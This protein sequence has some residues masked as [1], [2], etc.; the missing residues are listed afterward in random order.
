MRYTKAVTRACVWGLIVLKGK[1]IFFIL[2]S[3]YHFNYLMVRFLFFATACVE[4][5]GPSTL[6]KVLLTQILFQCISMGKSCNF[7]FFK[8][9]WK[10]FPHI[11][12]LDCEKYD[13]PGTILMLHVFPIR[14]H[15]SFVWEE[16]LRQLGRSL[17]PDRRNETF[18]G[19]DSRTVNLNSGWLQ[20]LTIL[21]DTLVNG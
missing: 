20:N 2:D 10:D 14:M 16:L 12:L 7:L 18:P 4:R 21:V 1:S 15:W 3:V 8:L 5:E 17:T 6:I 11:T 9:P 19:S 13:F